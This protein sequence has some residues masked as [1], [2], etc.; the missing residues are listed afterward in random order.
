VKAAAILF[1]A[2]VFCFG[3]GQLA[4]A[5]LEAHV[6]EVREALGDI[7]VGVLHGR[8]DRTEREVVAE[9]QDGGGANEYR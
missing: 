6:A 8:L 3:A 4:A 2:Q 9:L 7:E 1:A 5:A